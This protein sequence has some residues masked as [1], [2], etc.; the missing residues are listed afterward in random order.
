M[1]EIEK[2]SKD[3]GELSKPKLHLEHRK[4]QSK[5]SKNHSSAHTKSQ[6]ESLTTGENSHSSGDESEYITRIAG[7]N[8]FFLQYDTELDAEEENISN[9]NLASNVYMVHNKKRSTKNNI[10]GKKET[11]KKFSKT[12]KS[13]IS[14]TMLNLST[15]KLKSS[16]DK[17][18][19]IID[20]D[21]KS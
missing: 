19:I 16:Q 5:G 3:I 18:S 12:N 7:N 20:V 14:N 13:N 10:L 21:K 11:G 2:I 6:L 17:K 8:P 4:K 1:A 9:N 15:E